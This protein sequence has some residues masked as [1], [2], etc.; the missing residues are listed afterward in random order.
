MPAEPV[1]SEED[2]ALLGRLAD[3]VV[4]LRLETPAILTLETARPVSLLASQAMT[5][6]EPFVQAMFR[7]PEYRRFAALAERRDVIEELSRMIESRA[8][9][10]ESGAGGRGSP[11]AAP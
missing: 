11:G 7:L 10:R 6:F 5:F 1:L 9:A 2:R 8:D 4:E 3:R